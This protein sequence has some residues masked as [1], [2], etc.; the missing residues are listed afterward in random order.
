MQGLKSF[1]D[2][3]LEAHADRMLYLRDRWQ[4]EREYEDWSDYEKAIKALLDGGEEYEATKITK[5]PFKVFV[6][7]KILNETFIFI[8][9]A[10]GIDVKAYEG[11]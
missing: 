7:N 1:V 9:K 6:Y 8:I 2:R 11:K 10:N 4:D 5:R 3:I